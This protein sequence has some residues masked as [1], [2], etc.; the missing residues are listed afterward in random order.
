MYVRSSYSP[1]PISRGRT[2]QLFIRFQLALI[3][4]Q[5]T[6]PHYPR[7]HAANRPL[8]VPSTSSLL[9]L[10]WLST[11]GLVLLSYGTKR[12]FG[13]VIN[14]TARRRKA[15][16]IASVMTLMMYSATSSFCFSP[17]SPYYSSALIVG[18]SPAGDGMMTK[19][20]IGREVVAKLPV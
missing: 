2:T 7:P 10:L 19:T 20:Y 15:R 11:P 14:Q 3:Y 5:R 6:T 4:I 12:C 16:V 13:I 1:K 9:S 8:L 17:F 18:L